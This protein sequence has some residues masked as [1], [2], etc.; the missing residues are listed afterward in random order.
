MQN[1]LLYQRTL[2][3]PHGD[4]EQIDQCMAGKIEQIFSSMTPFERETVVRS[5]GLLNDAVA[6]VGCCGASRKNNVVCCN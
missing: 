2:I 6:K 3:S 1:S 4:K 5:L